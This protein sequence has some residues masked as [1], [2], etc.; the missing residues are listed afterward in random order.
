MKYVRNM[1][2]VLNRERGWQLLL[3]EFH[4]SIEIGDDHSIDFIIWIQDKYE[5]PLKIKDAKQEEN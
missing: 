5:L 1:D 2:S 3:D 4:L